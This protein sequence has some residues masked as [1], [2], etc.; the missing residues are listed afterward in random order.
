MKLSYRTLKE[1]VKN[2]N[3]QSIEKIGRYILIKIDNDST[4]A[5]ETAKIIYIMII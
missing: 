3:F 5:L 4:I 2:I 1:E